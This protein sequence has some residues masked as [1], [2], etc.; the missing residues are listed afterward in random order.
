[1]EINEAQKKILKAVIE[2]RKMLEDDSISGDGTTGDVGDVE[3]SGISKDV[4]PNRKTLNT[5]NKPFNTD[6]LGLARG[7]QKK[8]KN[9]QEK[10][11]SKAVIPIKAGEE[12]PKGYVQPKKGVKIAIDPEAISNP[13]KFIASKH[14]E[15]QK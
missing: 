4:D 15:E 5:A 7:G 9:L 1:M 11:P 12:P 6:Q 14:K 13:S 3:A 10:T 2:A 8:A